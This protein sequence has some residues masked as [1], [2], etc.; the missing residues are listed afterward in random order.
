[1][2]KFRI[3][4]V[5][6]VMVLLTALV[7]GCGGAKQEQQAADS[8]E[9]LIGGNLELSGAVATYGTALKNGAEMYFEEVNAEGGV[10]GNASGR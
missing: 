8:N 1:M 10:L 3:L 9:I 4:A 5:L 6:T 7:T 2:K